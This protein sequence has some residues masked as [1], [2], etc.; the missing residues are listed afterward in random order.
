V[1]RLWEWR[2]VGGEVVGSQ[3]ELKVPAGSTIAI[4]PR[5]VHAGTMQKRAECR[6]LV[7]MLLGLA[8]LDPVVQGLSPRVWLKKSMFPGQNLTMKC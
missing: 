3:I 4:S 1:P 7:P 2:W 5:R 8:L 6:I